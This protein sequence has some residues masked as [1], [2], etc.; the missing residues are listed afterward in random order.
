[1]APGLR[2]KVRAVWQALWAR[3]EFTEF[4]GILT[5]GEIR[6]PNLPHMRCVVALA[7]GCRIEALHLVGG[8]PHHH[9]R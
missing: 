8:G 6:Y 2:D 4:A 1:M 7:L 9:H 5:S 3:S